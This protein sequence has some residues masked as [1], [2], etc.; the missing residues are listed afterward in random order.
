MLALTCAGSAMH[1][2]LAVEGKPGATMRSGG[3]YDGWWNGGIRNTASFH[4]VIALLTE[5]IGNPTPQRIPL[6]VQRQVPGAD[7]AYPIAPQEWHSGSPSTTPSRSTARSR[8][9][10]ACAKHPLQ[11]LFDG[12]RPSNAA[13]VTR[14]QPIRGISEVTGQ[15]IFTSGGAVT[16]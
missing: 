11:F 13:I 3:P 16:A 2:R 1:A 14:G 10:G 5:M 7:L 9:R 6:V 8:L 15:P 4:N 12:R